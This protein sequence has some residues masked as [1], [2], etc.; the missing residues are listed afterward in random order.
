VPEV[1]R[2]FA[3]YEALRRPRVE[4]LVEAAAA[5]SSRQTQPRKRGQGDRDWIRDHHID[6][7]SP[8]EPD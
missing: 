4:R 2:A 5:L 3:T 6:W 8:V 1:P 7:D